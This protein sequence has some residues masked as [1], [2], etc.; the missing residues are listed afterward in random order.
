[1][2]LD[3][4]LRVDD[5]TGAVVCRHCTTRIG[6]TTAEPMAHAR[7]HERPSTEAGP[8]VH[9]D[10]AAFV[11]RKVLLR[12]AFCPGCLTLLSTE[13]VPDGEPSYRSWSLT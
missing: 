10:P 7:R 13:I 6:D 2:N 4:N 5:A 1:M 8:G 9:A 12:Q 11:D 3:L